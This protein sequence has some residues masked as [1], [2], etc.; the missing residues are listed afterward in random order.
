MAGHVNSH[1]SLMITR[2]TGHLLYLHNVAP[3]G[4][5]LEQLACRPTNHSVIT[6]EQLTP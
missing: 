4:S 1:R 3:E 5:C 6:H 2:G